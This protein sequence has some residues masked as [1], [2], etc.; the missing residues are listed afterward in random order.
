MARP[1]ATTIEV[2]R[3]ITYGVPM[4]FRAVPVAALLAAM[5]PPADGV[6]EAVTHDGFIAQLPADLVLNTDA[7]KAVAWLAIEPADHPWPPIPQKHESAGPF[8]I[9]WTGAAASTIRS[10]QWP[11]QTAKL[12]SQPSPSARWPVLAVD[13]ALPPT[14]LAGAGQA[15]YIVQCPA[16]P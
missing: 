12:I 15:L 9:V 13:L 3:D 5:A 14:D 6:I 4:T 2:A 10:E 11:Y 8:Y 16:L 7:S 1:D